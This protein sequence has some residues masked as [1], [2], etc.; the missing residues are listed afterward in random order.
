MRRLLLIILVQLSSFVIADEDFTA[1]E[2]CTLKTDANIRLNCFDGWFE[3][4]DK[5]AS[6]QE[7]RRGNET[8]WISA[9]REEFESSREDDR[10]VILPY[11]TNYFL[12][13]AY[14]THPNTQE[15]EG[16]D[17][18]STDAN[19]KLDH[20]ESKVQF[21]IKSRVMSHPFGKNSSLWV[22]YTQLSLWQLYNSPESSPFREINYEPEMYLQFI[23]PFSSLFITGRGE[24]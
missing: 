4:R 2:Q 8:R 22:A 14:D 11:R 16:N 9:Q 13:A 1:L 18:Y 3:R 21:S 24:R 6:V 20:M 15:Y 7:P 19:A 5:P 10:F 12:A 23:D 17:V